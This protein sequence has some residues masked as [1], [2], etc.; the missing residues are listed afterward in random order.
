[1]PSTRNEMKQSY[2]SRVNHTGLNPYYARELHLFSKTATNEFYTQPLNGKYACW[3][4]GYS[5]QGIPYPMP[6]QFSLQGKYQVRGMFCIPNCIKGEILQEKEF[7]E[8]RRLEL[9]TMML[10]DVYSFDE[11]IDVVPK[12]CF[13]RYG[14]EVTHEE[15]LLYWNCLPK[16]T[17]RNYAPFIPSRPEV[18]LGIR[19]VELMNLSAQDHQAFQE[20][21]AALAENARQP[22]KEQSASAQSLKPVPETSNSIASAQQAQPDGY[23]SRLKQSAHKYSYVDPASVFANNHNQEAAINAAAITSVVMQTR[24]E[25]SANNHQSGGASQLK[26]MLSDDSMKALLEAARNDNALIPS[27]PRTQD[28]QKQVSR[29][30]QRSTTT[31]NGNSGRVKAK[32]VARKPSASSSELEATSA[33]EVQVQ[34]RANDASASL[35]DQS[36]NNNKTSRKKK[37]S[38][39]NGTLNPALQEQPTQSTQMNLMD[40]MKM[41]K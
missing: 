38:I 25:N 36:L 26:Q 8:G 30:R 6:I 34:S 22:K 29:P 9:L 10:S 27:R 28:K 11:D 17:L 33:I 18:E 31:S 20:K 19:S 21:Q 5:I 13:E 2:L 14:G 15:Y 24:A 4:C 16:I 23:L 1:M 3:Y 7:Y 39:D 40:M 37:L 12:Y 35:N 32:R 41:T